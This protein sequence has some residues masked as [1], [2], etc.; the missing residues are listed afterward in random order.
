MKFAHIVMS[1]LAAAIL[2]APSADAAPSVKRNYSGF[3]I[4]EAVDD[5]A[6]SFIKAE[7]SQLKKA[8][9]ITAVKIGDADLE[10]LV[11]A[12]PDIQELTVAYTKE[13]TSIAPV[14]KLTG[15]TKFDGRDIHNVT[16]FTPLAELT[17]LQKLS[18]NSNGLSGDLK[19]MSKLAGLTS[20]SVDSR[21][22]TSFEGLPFLPKLTSA[23]FIHA[24]PAD[25][26][27]LVA[28]MPK[29]ST[30]HLNYCKINDLSPLAQLADLE[31][32]NLYGAEV[33]DFSPLA[34]CA[35]LKKLTYYGM[36]HCDF[37]T[38]AAL[39]QVGELDGGLTNLADISWIAELPNLKYFDVFAESITDYS[40]L[41]KTNIERFTIWNMRQPVGDLGVI[42]QM[43][44]L[45]DLKLWSVNGAF[46]SAGLSGLAELER[47]TISSDFNKKGGE[48]FDL[49][50]TR[51][52]A[53]VREI[54]L[55]GAVVANADKMGP[56]PVLERVRLRQVTG[57][58]SFEALKKCP[59]LK[60]IEIE[61]CPDIP[62]SELLGF[63]T[64]VKISRR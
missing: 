41:A 57:F 3:E 59:G 64:K 49:A 13:L 48:A 31:Y 45:K 25:L 55:Q 8:F 52:W 19:W 34:Q 2:Y 6:I 60:Y 1:L 22:V 44:K 5:N 58:T 46:N 4:K 20:V 36:K 32:L 29:L 42:G 17:S 26:A 62:D 61:G 54:D 53:K 27:P 21:N 9:G 18:I 12:F 38:L 23:S 63:D 24:A 10:R 40:P 50:A 47:F 11:A 33:K 37:T 14:A 51:G 43:P 30:L 7:K 15:L 35:K 16:D 39:K 56:M 28:S